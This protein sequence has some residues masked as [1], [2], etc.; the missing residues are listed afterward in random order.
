MRTIPVAEGQCTWDISIQE[1]GSVAGFFWVIEDN[2]HIYDTLNVVLQPGMLINVRD[3]VINREVVDYYKL[4]SMKP[5]SSLT[6]EELEFAFGGGGFSGGFDGGFEG[7]GG[8][9]GFSSGFSNGF[10]I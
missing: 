2:P 1:Y 10:N 8:S 3:E 7:G 6:A 4:N 9:G 5:V